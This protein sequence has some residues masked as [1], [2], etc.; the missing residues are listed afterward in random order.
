MKNIELKST[1]ENL[2]NLRKENQLNGYL[3]VRANTSCQFN[4]ESSANQVLSSIF[5]GII[6]S[7]DG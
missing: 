1:F 6:S 7:S 3:L 5:G 2:A 4:L